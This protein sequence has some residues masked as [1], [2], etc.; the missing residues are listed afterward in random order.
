MTCDMCVHE[1]ICD[2]WH[3]L[4]Y[5]NA[6]IEGFEL[7]DYDFVVNCENNHDYTDCKYFKDDGRN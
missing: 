4:L 3:D 6:N 5:R 2:K 1:K 7:D